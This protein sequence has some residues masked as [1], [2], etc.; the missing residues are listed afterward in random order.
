[1][2]APEVG[3]AHRRSPRLQGDAFLV[4]ADQRDGR[5]DTGRVVVAYALTRF[6]IAQQQLRSFAIVAATARVAGPIVHV[7]D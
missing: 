5:Q 4:D 6:K 3:Q 2:A 1:M 7:Y